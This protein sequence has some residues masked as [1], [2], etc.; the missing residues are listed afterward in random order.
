MLSLKVSIVDEKRAL[1]PSPFLIRPKEASDEESSIP[2][3][4][5]DVYGANVR[6]A[7]CNHREKFWGTDGLI[8]KRRGRNWLLSAFPHYVFF[9]PQYIVSLIFSIARG[10]G[11]K[12]SV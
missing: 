12:G 8:P 2:V 6:D 7:S 5:V 1:A 4:R 11:S 10:T 9:H 3:A